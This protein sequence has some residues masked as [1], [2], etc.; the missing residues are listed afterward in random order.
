MYNQSNKNI[1]VEAV[2]RAKEIG[3]KAN[4]FCSSKDCVDLKRVNEL[5]I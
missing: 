5:F 1:N 3:K 2:K 4:V